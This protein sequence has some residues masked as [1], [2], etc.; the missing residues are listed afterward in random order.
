MTTC[1]PSSDTARMKVPALL[2]MIL[3]VVPLLAGAGQ[4]YK[5]TDEKGQVH[6]GDAPPAERKATARPIE[7]GAP[8][9]EEDR[10]RAERRHAHDL[11]VLAE[12]ASAA[13][14]ASAS[15]APPTA[16]G[17]AASSSGSACEQAWKAYDES[18]ACINPYRMSGGRIRP[19]AFEHCKELRQPWEC[20]APVGH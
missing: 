5:W 19:E 11:Q 9:S 16:A 12:A 8:P 4:P 6:Y 18:Y 10:K 15:A 17:K 3:A 2:V 7:T 1:R 20:P 14:A 13:A